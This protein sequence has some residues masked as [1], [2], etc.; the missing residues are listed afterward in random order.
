MKTKEAPFLLRLTM[1]NTIPVFP[2]LLDDEVCS[3]RMIKLGTNREYFTALIIATL[4]VLKL[5]DI[6][7]TVSTLLILAWQKTNFVAQEM[8][9]LIHLPVAFYPYIIIFHLNIV[10]NLG[11]IQI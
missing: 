9:F 10:D 8:V 2:C 3:L 6:A 1:L 7:T 5:R 11:F 4:V